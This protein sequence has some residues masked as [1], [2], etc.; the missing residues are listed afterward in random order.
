MGHYIWNLAVQNLYSPAV[1]VSYHGSL[2]NGLYALRLL[3]VKY[4]R[5]IFI[6]VGKKTFKICLQRML[7]KYQPECSLTDEGDLDM[8]MDT[9]KKVINQWIINS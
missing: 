9:V 3:G 8:P 2:Y 1:T 4:P 6:C 7:R 5:L